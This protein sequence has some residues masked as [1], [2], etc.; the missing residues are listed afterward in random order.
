[1][2]KIREILKREWIGKQFVYVSKYGSETIGEIGDVILINTFSM[3]KESADVIRE[4]V[5][6]KSENEP[7]SH[8]IYNA[9]ETKKSIERKDFK[10]IGSRPKISIKSTNGQ[11]YK[12]DEIYILKP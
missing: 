11:I 9:I 6:L 12:L 5:K 1:M 3:D 2:D 4:L 8:V 7:G 10:W